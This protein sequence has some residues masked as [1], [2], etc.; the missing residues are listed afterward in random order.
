MP[1]GSAGTCTPMLYIGVHIHIVTYNLKQWV[2]YILLFM[3]RNT[4]THTRSDVCTCMCSPTMETQCLPLL[5][6]P[7]TRVSVGYITCQTFRCARQVLSPLHHLSN[8]ICITSKSKNLQL[9]LYFTKSN[10]FNKLTA[11]VYF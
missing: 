4:H 10:C 7:N 8:S 3:C 6:L 2:N 9:F 11:K 1:L 5:C